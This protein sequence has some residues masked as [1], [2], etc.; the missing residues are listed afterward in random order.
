MRCSGGSSGTV[1]GVPLPAWFGMEPGWGCW[2]PKCRGLRCPASHGLCLGPSRGSLEELW[3]GSG[4][5]RGWAAS[6]SLC[7]PVGETWDHIQLWPAVGRGTAR[8]NHLWLLQP[9]QHFWIINNRKKVGVLLRPAGT[10]S[11]K[12]SSAG[13]D[14]GSVPGTWDCH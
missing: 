13:G 3:D 2:S 8:C 12:P 14:P 4:A 5:V 6:S 11:G 9:C 7:H 10:R 1:F